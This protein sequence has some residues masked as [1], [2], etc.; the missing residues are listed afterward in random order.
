[1]NP[2]R[3]TARANYPEPTTRQTSEYELILS[4]ADNVVWQKLFSISSSRDR[5]RDAGSISVS[6]ANT[7]SSQSLGVLSVDDPGVH[8][9]DVKA[10]KSDLD[11][12]DLTIAVRRNVQQADKRLYIP[13]IALAV[14]GVI[15]LLLTAP[16]KRTEASP[17]AE[18]PSTPHGH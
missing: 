1:M 5:D 9:I 8:T 4:R 6:T 16:R 17:P 13:G 18:S 2:I 14:A 11:I 7:R 12:A 10:G 3:M 15:G